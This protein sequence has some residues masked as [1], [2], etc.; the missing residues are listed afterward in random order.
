MS[1][2]R[3][4][5]K[6]VVNLI[7]QDASVTGRFTPTEIRRIG[8]LCQSEIS[9]KTKCYETS[10]TQGSSASQR[11]YALP[12]NFLVAQGVQYAGGY[13]QCEQIYE[14]PLLANVPERMPPTHFWVR[15]SV[16]GFYPTP[17]SAVNYDVLYYA[18]AP[19]Y[20]FQIRH[21]A[22]NSSTSAVITTTKAAITLSI[23]G[24]S[25]SGD[26]VMDL[27][28]ET[29]DTVAEVVIQIKALGK[30]FTAVKS[31]L[32]L[33]TTSMTSTHI[34]ESRSDV[35]VHGKTDYAFFEPV[36]SADAQRIIPVGIVFKFK[37]KDRELSA[38]EIEKSEY[39]SLMR[40]YAGRRARRRMSQRNV[41][42]KSA[43]RRRTGGLW[44]S[45]TLRLY[46]P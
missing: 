25:N 42:I 27:T 17:S 11:E 7:G 16:M 3:D 29:Y 20:C 6:E 38:E 22:G 15:G 21:D 39:Y 43:Y 9:E 34:L 41:G 32:L 40:A 18:I 13:P 4:I 5:Q 44:A 46:I 19:D 10:A 23:V 31:D 26:T 24:G 8:G 28:A 35:N 36:I 1:N 37:M 14:I 12:V 2:W 33:N 45:G 30:G